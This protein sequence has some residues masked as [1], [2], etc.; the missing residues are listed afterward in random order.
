MSHYNSEIKFNMQHI[1][2][3]IN[4]RFFW[5]SLTGG[6]FSYY[7]SLHPLEELSADCC[8]D[9]WKMITRTRNQVNQLSVQRSSSHGVILSWHQFCNSASLIFDYKPCQD[10]QRSLL[11]GIWT[12]KGQIFCTHNLFHTGKLDK[13]PSSMK[14]ISFWLRS[15]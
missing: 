14:A 4:I 13:A 9:S 12:F 8:K 2:A 11:L 7:E 6:Q 1:H 3:A 10:S 15:L 5:F